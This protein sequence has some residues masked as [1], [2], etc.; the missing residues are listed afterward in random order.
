MVF[1]RGWWRRGEWDNPP[2]WKVA[3]FGAGAP[4]ADSRWRR[5]RLEYAIA[6]AIFGLVVWGVVHLILLVA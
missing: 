5:Q 2:W 3:A 6:V 4:G 1:Q